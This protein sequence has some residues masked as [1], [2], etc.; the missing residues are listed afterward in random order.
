MASELHTEG[1]Q[2][3]LECLSEVSV[4][5]AT[6][7]VGLATDASPAE[8]A[9]VADLTEI[10]DAGYARQTINSDDTDMVSS[11]AG[12]NDFK[13]TLKTVNFANS[14]G[15]PWT[16]VNIAFL[17]DKSDDSG[18]LISSGPVTNAPNT[19]ADGEDMDV[20]MTLQLNG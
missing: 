10:S 20:T 2:F 11:G 6:Y 1:L 17:T 8:N 19:I 14:S 4:I 16:A 3:L 18:S 13:M 9:T 5:P 15:N 12:T 7:Y